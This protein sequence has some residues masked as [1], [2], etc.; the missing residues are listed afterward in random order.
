M[1]LN[2]SNHPWLFNIN[3]I[4]RVIMDLATIFKSPLI[5]KYLKGKLSTHVTSMVNNNKSPIFKPNYFCLQFSSATECVTIHLFAG[6]FSLSIGEECYLLYFSLIVGVMSVDSPPPL[7]TIG[8]LKGGLH[9]G[10][11]EFFR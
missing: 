11:F 2:G 10:Q 7:F 8:V 5:V 1:T 4:P 9:E 6:I 3:G